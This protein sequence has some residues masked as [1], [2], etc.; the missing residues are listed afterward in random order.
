MVQQAFPA[1]RV[2]LRQTISR[3]VKH[4]YITKIY[5]SLDFTIHSKNS[6][7]RTLHSACKPSIVYTWPIRLK[8]HIY[9]LV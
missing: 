9:T 2:Y 7:V 3:L 8:N 5:L 6:L 4:V 1:H